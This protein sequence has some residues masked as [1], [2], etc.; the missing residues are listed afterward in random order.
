MEIDLRGV[1]PLSCV[2]LG[3]GA[4]AWSTTRALC[5]A[6]GH[7]LY[8]DRGAWRADPAAFRR[9]AITLIAFARYLGRPMESGVTEVALRLAQAVRAR[10]L[11]RRVRRVVFWLLAGVPYA[12][13]LTFY[14]CDDWISASPFEILFVY[15]LMMCLTC[16]LGALLAWQPARRSWTRLGGDHRAVDWCLVVLHDASLAMQGRVDAVRSVNIG[17]DEVGRVLG[18]YAAQSVVFPSSAQRSAVRA[19]TAQVH[20]A[21]VAEADGLL[22]DGQAA[23]PAV[24][25]TLL[26]LLDRLVA[27]RW[28]ALLDIEAPTNPEAEGDES[29]TES[30]ETGRDR[31]IAAVGS[32]LAA[33]G[34]VAAGAFGVPLAAAIPGALVF[35]FGPAMLWGGKSLRPS[36]QRMLASM[37]EGIGRAGTAPEPSAV[38]GLTPESP[39]TEPA[40]SR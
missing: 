2:A 1:L 12:G 34:L 36:A 27:G 18:E 31:L 29:Q 28:L 8:W 6:A 7:S 22:R 24:I 33:G 21:L 17:M 26:T 39:R 35:L 38:Q 20:R 11:V 37:H 16:P 30:A 32:V 23:L 9:G 15:A 19:H 40:Q 13:L 10:R 3:S 4:L 25:G 5:R 14:L